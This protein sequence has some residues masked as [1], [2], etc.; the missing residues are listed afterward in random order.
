MIEEVINAK[1]LRTT[2][3]LV[4]GGIIAFVLVRGTVEPTASAVPQKME[5]RKPII[6]RGVPAVDSPSAASRP[7][8]A[9]SIPQ[10]K[11]VKQESKTQSSENPP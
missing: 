2:A 4:C 3:L 11:E 8:G 7:A 10:T 1:I 6:K 5:L 9:A